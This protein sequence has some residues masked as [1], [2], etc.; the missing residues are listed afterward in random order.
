MIDIEVLEILG[1]DPT[2]PKN[3]GNNIQKDV[4]V[5]LEHNAIEGLSR[6]NRNQLLDTYLV[7][8]NCKLI[9]AP[10][11]NPE[12]KAALSEQ[13]IKRDKAIEAKQKVT[14]A[15]I[16]C[17]G[18]VISLTISSKEKDTNLLRLLMDTS[19]MLCDCQH[20]DTLTRRNYVIS[21]IKKDMKESLLSAKTD[22]FLF[23]DKLPD[24]LKAAKAINK[25][26]AELKI[27]TTP[28]PGPNEKTSELFKSTFR[29]PLPMSGSAISKLRD[30]P[31]C[32]DI[33]SFRGSNREVSITTW[34]TQCR[35]Y[36]THMAYTKTVAPVT[37]EP[38]NGGRN[39]ETTVL[40][41]GALHQV[42]AH[43]SNLNAVTRRQLLNGRGFWITSLG[44]NLEKLPS[45]YLT[46]SSRYSDTVAMDIARAYDEGR[47]TTEPPADMPGDSDIGE[48]GVILNRGDIDTQTEGTSQ[49][50]SSVAAGTATPPSRRNS[51]LVVPVRE[52]RT[53]A[54]SFKG[55]NDRS[56]NKSPGLVALEAYATNSDRAATQPY[57]STTRGVLARDV[58][59]VQEVAAYVS[60][61]N[62]SYID[63]A[64]ALR[65]LLYAFPRARDVWNF[66]SYDAR[67]LRRQD[68]N[69]RT[70]TQLHIH[71]V[72]EA[73]RL[74]VRMV[75]ITLPAFAAHLKN[76]D[77]EMANEGADGMSLAGMDTSWAAIPIC[78]DMLGNPW[79]LEFIM[80]FTTTALWA[81]K[82]CFLSSG[83][84]ATEALPANVLFSGMPAAHQVH[85]PGPTKLVLVLV[86]ENTYAQETA[87]TISGINLNVYRGV[88]IATGQ[89]P[90][91]QAWVDVQNAMYALWTQENYPSSC[92][93][94]VRALQY[95]EDNFCHSMAFQI[96]VSLAAEM[97][98]YMPESPRLHGDEQGRYED[99]LGGGWTI[100]AHNFNRRHPLHTTS[101]VDIGTEEEICARIRRLL[102]GYSFASVSPIQQ[103]AQNYATLATTNIVVGNN[104]V[105]TETHWQHQRPDL[106]NAQYQCNT[107]NSAYRILTGMGFIL[108]DDY[109]YRFRNADGVANVVTMQ[110]VALTLSLGLALASSDISRAAWSGVGINEDPF[111]QTP[112]RKWVANMTHGLV[113]LSNT[114][115]FMR[116]IIGANHSIRAEILLYTGTQPGHET[117]G[118]HV[119]M[120]YPSFIQWAKQFNI[121]YKG[122]YTFSD[123]VINAQVESPHILIDEKNNLSVSW[124]GTVQDS[125]ANLPVSYLGHCNAVPFTI[126]LSVE[127]WQLL[128]CSTELLHPTPAGM[129]S[130]LCTISINNRYR[131]VSRPG[132]VMV[133]NK[134]AMRKDRETWNVSPLQYPVPPNSN[135]LRGPEPANSPDHPSHPDGTKVLPSRVIT[136]V[137][138]KAD[139]PSAVP[140]A[141]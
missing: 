42:V 131:H 130:N 138:P 61:Y 24:T 33:T 29:A 94:M 30:V 98:A 107:A 132:R 105:G 16:A 118:S 117:W 93:N 76:L 100:G 116:R 66:D 125:F 34:N 78:S 39:R 56:P 141:E 121:D 15:A 20:S 54:M 23:G 31:T 133:V 83:Q 95:M 28:K 91:A 112:V 44:A 32:Q 127:D 101:N 26:G 103:H 40:I 3:Y 122:E 14:A 9:G 109:S 90:F 49:S 17:L 70:L 114:D 113:L 87:I 80:C 123:G 69:T 108:K 99:E 140:T 52:V 126:P 45:K 124:V 97:S 110:G 60:T 1:I 137:E 92:Q 104:Y 74:R 63:T 136:Q 88:R 62:A 12:L 134:F 21:S 38:Q 13:V 53:V 86:D 81:G 128:S 43:I 96:A 79:L 55:H 18:Q 50:I 77:P 64:P 82:T 102:R 6:E 58:S 10:V 41:D 36:P 106:N 11:L 68:L 75:A 48:Y 47:L 4:A 115:T 35:N 46:R 7:P 71:Q 59:S 89:T 25:S 2:A 111:S 51:S 85:I 65:G 57:I 73:D 37:M 67:F 139:P 129:M 27:T 119:C 5:R 120:P 22:T 84:H 8:N 72:A 135:F 19:R